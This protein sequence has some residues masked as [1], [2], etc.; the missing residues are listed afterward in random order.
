MS[1]SIVYSTIDSPPVLTGLFHE[2]AIEDAEA[3]EAVTS[4]GGMGFCIDGIRDSG[5]ETIS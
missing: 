4:L 5:D 2:T 1:Q 3:I